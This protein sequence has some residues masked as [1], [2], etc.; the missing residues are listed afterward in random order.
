MAVRP[1]VTTGVALLSAGAIV[2]GTPALFVP[3]DQVTVAAPTAAEAPSKLTVEQINLLAAAATLADAFFIGHGALVTGDGT[4]SCDADGAVCLDGFVGAAYWIVDQIIPDIDVRTAGRPIDQVFFEEGF[5][6]VA[7]DFTGRIA[8]EIDSIDPTGGRLDLATRVD[9]FFDGGVTLLVQNLID[10]NLPDGPVGTWFK[11]LNDAFFDGGITG[12]VTYVLQSIGVVSSTAEVEDAVT[13]GTESA[14]LLASKGSELT[15]TSLPEVGSLLKLPEFGSPLKKFQAPTAPKLLEEVD[16]EDEGAVEGDVE[17]TPK[18]EGT[19]LQPLK[20]E[21]PTIEAPKFEVPKLDLDLKPKVKE[22]AAQE[23]GEVKDAGGTD[24]KTG[25]KVT[26]HVLI[27][28]SKPKD[29]Y[30]GKKFL[31][32]L[33]DAV[34]KATGG[35]KDSSD[36]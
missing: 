32:K 26:P 8:D 18:V 29:D 22:V 36:K 14:T 17:S 15:S 9:D 12:A 13:S 20:F 28:N 21:L 2:A 11:G 4:G 31:N 16:A 10:D 27:G 24:T 1:L 19:N 6:G 30:N 23:D 25:N 7:H 35:E 3:H 5:T 33:K 34:D